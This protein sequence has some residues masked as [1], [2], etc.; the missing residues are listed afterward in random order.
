MT[1]L[2]H[3]SIGELTTKGGNP[4]AK[5][6]SENNNTMRLILNPVT[7]ASVV[8]LIF[9]F[10]SVMALLPGHPRDSIEIRMTEYGDHWPFAI[11]QGRLRCEGAGAVILTVQ[12]KDYAVNGMASTRYASM[13]P[14]WKSDPG[15]VGRI[16]SRGLTLCKW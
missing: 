11:Q 5:E 1:Y 12:G 8:G 2:P 9:G 15:D 3:A 16:I 14:V 13:Q 4:F 6:F 10:L 7:L